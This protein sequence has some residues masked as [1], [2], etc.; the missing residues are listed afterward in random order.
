MET[1][2]TPFSLVYGLVLL[3]WNTVAP[4]QD[5]R[6]VPPAEQPNAAEAAYFGGKNPNLSVGTIS[7]TAAIQLVTA[8][9]NDL[10]NGQFEAAHRRLAGGF[11][12]YGPGYN[13]KLGTD[14]LLD[15]WAHDG[16]LF[17]DQRLTIDAGSVTT[18]TNG[19]N[20]GR[21]VYLNVVWTAIER[22][23][24]GKPVRIP[25]HQLAR[26]NNGLIERTY[27]SYGN[28]QIFYALGFPIYANGPTHWSPVANKKR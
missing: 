20:R 16:Q 5:F 24:A 17:A 7:D 8:F 1:T 15:Q 19:D 21:W 9:L 13:D 23:G 27:T 4:A 25:F 18:V 2:T 10:T 12:A 22:S 11:V 26:V 28:D 3:L 6:A 14:N